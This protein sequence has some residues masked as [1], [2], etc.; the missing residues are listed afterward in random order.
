MAWT[1]GYAW[2]GKPIML[3]VPRGAAL[4]K[5]LCPNAFK[6]STEQNEEF[7]CNY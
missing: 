6:A 5:Q 7:N 1:E 2:E 4:S 3:F